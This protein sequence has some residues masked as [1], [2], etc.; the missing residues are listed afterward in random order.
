MQYI[1][2]GWWVLPSA[3]L[4]GG[5]RCS[6]GLFWDPQYERDMDIW[7]S[8]AQGHRDDE[9]TE[10]P[11]LWGAAERAGTAQPGEE[12]SNAFTYLK[13]DCRED[14]ARLFLTVLSSRTRSHG[15]KLEHVRFHPNIRKHLLTVQVTEHCRRWPTDCGVSLEI[16]KRCLDM[17]LGGVLQ[18]SLLE[19][20]TSRETCQPQPFYNSVSLHTRENL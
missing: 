20:M 10:A 19:Q 15:H 16:L 5:C 12:L 14:K 7:E 1:A 3:Q 18:E 17:V 11:L 6:A 4:W 13:G 8:P 2:Q 9:G